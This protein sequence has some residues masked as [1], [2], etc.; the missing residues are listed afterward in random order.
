MMRALAVSLFVTAVSACSSGG[1]GS[2]DADDPAPVLEV[3]SP[4][5]GALA[6]GAEV[7]VTGRVTDNGKVRVTVAGV[8]ADVA[9][10]GTFSASVP[11]PDGI[12]LLETHAIDSAGQDV[13]D[14]R[15][16]LA[17]TLAPSDG[18]TTGM[19]GARAGAS[20]LAAVGN[21]VANQANTIDFNAAA[22]AMNPV[23]DN[24]GCLGA[25]LNITSVSLGDLA[26]DLAPASGLL[27]TDVTIPDIDVRIH[28]NFKVAC[29]GGHTDITVRAT[30]AMIHGDLGLTVAGNKVATSLPN[31]TVGF[32]NFSL[33][34]G[35][36]PGAIE[37]LLDGEARKAVEKLLTT[38][39]KTRVPPMADSA[40]AG[41]IAHPLATSL[42][43]HD[44]TI[45][46]TPTTVSITPTELFVGVA[47]RIRVTGGEGGTFMT[48]STAQSSTTMGSTHGLGLAVDDDIANS[49]FAG[50]WAAGALDQSVSVDAIPGIGGLL[51]DDARSL[52]L[53]LSL[54]PTVS[55]DS[56]E[57]VLA[58]GDAILSVKDASNT[59]IQRIAL[60][61]KTSLK[62]AP[63]Q[64]GTVR[65]TVGSPTLYAQ[66]LAITDA[67][68]S[69]LSDEQLEGLITGA[70]GLVS[71]T[72]N[73]TLGNVPM[74]SIA[75]IQL[76]TPSLEAA[77][78]FVI[79]DV[80]VM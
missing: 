34:I 14:V 77:T 75:G 11:V 26:V 66:T 3:T 61:L 47:T 44:T 51:D 56:G 45:T 76:G 4:A 5:R 46:I 79:A 55:T 23:Y 67:V 36:V 63:T 24:G 10:D 2:S 52:D 30:K 12:T 72:L 49:L 29:I 15:A 54:P 42:L 28:A 31:V 58:L 17:G 13:R 80:P 40:L 74:P 59:E 48:T 64:S 9:D 22:Q 6:E 7:T 71:S 60:S 20:A 19:L 73:D 8:E 38:Q 53:T 27:T 35:G 37:D 33:D 43:G 21:A 78:G 32:E 69:P 18:S 50:L 41:L 65:F 70:W 68:Q 1:A 39:I 16:V 25:T 57:L 62:A